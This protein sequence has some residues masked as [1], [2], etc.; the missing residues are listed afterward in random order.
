MKIE[1][2]ESL[3]ISWLKHIKKCAIVQTN[4]KQSFEWEEHDYEFVD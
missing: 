3:A 2:G 4:W 1:M